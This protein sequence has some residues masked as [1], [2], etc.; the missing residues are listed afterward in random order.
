MTSNKIK[1]FHCGFLS[2]LLSCFSS[3]ALLVVLSTLLPVLPLASVCRSN[4]AECSQRPQGGCQ[5]PP[6]PA[7]CSLLIR[8]RPSVNSSVSLEESPDYCFPYCH[9]GKCSHSIAL[10]QSED[11]TE[12]KKQKHLTAHRPLQDYCQCY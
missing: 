7:L 3:A 6:L 8:S 9:V 12:K 11:F 10:Q 5:R 2:F 1:Q 4:C